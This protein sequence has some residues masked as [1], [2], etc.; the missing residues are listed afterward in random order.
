MC[1]LSV[2]YKPKCYQIAQ[3]KENI[4]IYILLI[5]TWDMT[6][7]PSMS[8]VTHSLVI[9]KHETSWQMQHSATHSLGIKLN[10][11]WWEHLIDACNSLAVNR[12]LK[13]W[14]IE[15]GSGSLT[16][17]LLWDQYIKLHDWLSFTYPLL[18]W[19]W[20][21]CIKLIWLTCSVSCYSKQ[22]YTNL[23]PYFQ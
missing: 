23:V 14:C 19:L 17:I 10:E 1:S 5:M 21:N 4:V 13:F 8:N 15:L 20:K 6:Q 9:E 12:K 18:I 16:H 11:I 2:G 22:C 7:M 3:Q